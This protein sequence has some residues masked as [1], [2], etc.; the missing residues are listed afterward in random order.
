VSNVTTAGTI[1]DTSFLM[2]CSG[3][4]SSSSGLHGGYG[5]SVP[6]GAGWTAGGDVACTVLAGIYCF[7]Q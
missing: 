3:W 5:N 4:T 2:H 1:T 7:E 6:T